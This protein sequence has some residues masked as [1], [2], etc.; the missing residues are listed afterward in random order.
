MNKQDE[1]SAQRNALLSVSCTIEERCRQDQ[2]GREPE[3]EGNIGVTSPSHPR[4][5]P[6]P[7]AYGCGDTQVVISTGREMPIS[8]V[9]VC[10][11]NNAQF[12]THLYLRI[13]TKGISKADLQTSGRG[14]FADERPEFGQFAV[15]GVEIDARYLFPRSILKF[16]KAD[17]DVVVPCIDTEQQTGSGCHAFTVDSDQR[18]YFIGKGHPNALQIDH[19]LLRQKRK[20]PT[21]YG[22]RCLMFP[23][24][25]PP[26]LLRMFSK[27]KLPE[28]AERQDGADVTILQKQACQNISSPRQRGEQS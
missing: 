6:N 26:P 14:T 19:G 11:K 12:K 17:L 28:Q 18:C 25:E 1:L 22:L 9:Q 7:T 3:E 16:R 2:E 27:G 21:P 13:R 8:H 5:R 23:G 4:S 20:S 24:V 15:L 10:N